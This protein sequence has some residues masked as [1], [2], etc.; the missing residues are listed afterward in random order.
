MKAHSAHYDEATTVL[1]GDTTNDVA[2]GIQAGAHVIGVATGRASTEELTAAG[3][4]A[5]FADLTQ[6]DVLP[7]ILGEPWA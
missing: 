7:A 6:P 4:D 5:V 1:I 2:A 3:A